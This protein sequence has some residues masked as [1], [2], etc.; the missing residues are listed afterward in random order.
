[1]LLKDSI[2]V[3]DISS[4]LWQS[5]SVYTTQEQRYE[6]LPGEKIIL[7]KNSLIKFFKNIML[8]L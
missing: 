1:M 6:N 7:K 8:L 5:L 2:N 4:R 3:A